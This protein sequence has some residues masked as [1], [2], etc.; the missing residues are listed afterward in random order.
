MK[1]AFPAIA[2]AL[3]TGCGSLAEA[4]TGKNYAWRPG[5]YN[6]VAAEIT[7]EFDQHQAV[8]TIRAPWVNPGGYVEYFLRAYN[9]GPERPVS[10]QLYVSITFQDWAF[11]NSAHSFGRRLPVT[12]IDRRVGSCSSYSGCSVV[13][14]IAVNLTED[15]LRSFSTTGL[16]FQVS[17]PGNSVDISVPAAYIR[18]F[19]DSLFGRC[20]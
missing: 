4:L 5:D 12:Q 2:L 7:S 8:T 1:R 18:A 20:P 9:Y 14:E 10:A 13:E 15:D 6:A 19:C 16:A 3:L 11:L 17:G